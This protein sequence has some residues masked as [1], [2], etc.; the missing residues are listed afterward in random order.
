MVETLL[1]H[2]MTGNFSTIL[3]LHRISP[4]KPD[5]LPANENMNVPPEALERFIRVA[6]SKRC[7][8][9]SL[10]ELHD[11]LVKQK[12]L[13]KTIVLTADDGYNDNYQYGLEVINA[14][15]T[16]LCIYV[17]TG[18]PDRTAKLW[19]FALEDALH[20]EIESVSALPGSSASGSLNQR[21]LHFRT[22]FLERYAL[23][24]EKFFADHFPAFRLNWSAYQETYCLNWESIATLSRYP[25]ITLGAHT[26]THS[27]LSALSPED[28]W[29]EIDQSRKKIQDMI[30][31]KVAHF[32]YPFGGQT[33]ATQ[34]EFRIAQELGFK[35]ATTTIEGYV[36][37]G[38]MH[39]LTSLPRFMLGPSSSLQKYTGWRQRIKS[40]IKG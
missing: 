2:C 31:Q 39:Y 30:G 9:I 17:T 7:A 36:L 32:C 27:L 24:P 12:K 37:P 15:R 35:T 11:R 1:H 4:I 22:I 33:E 8:F 29:Y 5:A 34:R 16:P 21:F 38:H 23:F 18:F 14:N 3:M 28:A 26:L 6:K 13:T 20:H 19:W 25:L 40:A 10:D